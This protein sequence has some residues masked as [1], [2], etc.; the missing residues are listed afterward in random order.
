M[1]NFKDKKM[2]KK[3]L[4]SIGCLAV[5]TLVSCE[6]KEN[7]LGTWVEPIPGQETVEQGFTLKENGE[8]ESVNMATLV[9][10]H[11][12]KEGDLLLLNAT[13]IGNGVSFQF[14]DTMKIEKL[15]QDSLIL[16]RNGVV[17]RYHKD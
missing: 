4:M 6:Q 10:D 9:Y 12:Q 3:L 1:Y 15:T 13:S 7:L 8:A 16:S 17:I 5:T 2:G 14:T 11:W